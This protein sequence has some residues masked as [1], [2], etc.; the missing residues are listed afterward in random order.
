MQRRRE[1]GIRM[2]LGAAPSHV[3]RVVLRHGLTIGALGVLLGVVFALA[4]GRLVQPL[5]FGVAAT[6][7]VVLF[8]T[9]ALLLVV[10]LT[11]TLLPTRLA[12]R[13]DPLRVLRSE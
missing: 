2:A 10:V 1:I 3:R 13:T 4:I 8:G 11:A 7:P 9:A 5:L 6:D 12:T